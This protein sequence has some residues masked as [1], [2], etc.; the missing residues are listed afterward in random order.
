MS[1]PAFTARATEQESLFRDRPLIRVVNYHNTPRIRA[2]QM[3]RELQQYSQ[4]FTS[5]NE[6][7]LRSYIQTG[8]WKKSKPGM[9]PV[10]YEGYRN[11]Y[12]VIAPLLE[13]YGFVGWFFIITEFI[14]GPVPD[15]VTYAKGHHIGMQTREYP[16]GRY[17]LT[18]Q[19]IRELSK[20]HVIASHARNHA[21]LSAMSEEARRAEIFGSQEDFRKNLGRPV[22]AFSSLRGP[23]QNEHPEVDTA[24][25]VQQA[26]YEFVFSNYRIQ[27][28]GN[29]VASAS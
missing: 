25:L 7:E 23:A 15:Q 22:L 29:G 6:A 21:E 3:E 20:K 19:E 14:K 11:G 17:A 18:W 26:G 9:I 24:K 4:A 1:T 2:E 10:L 16:E 28:V 12:D 5:V 27:R 13:K 8:Q